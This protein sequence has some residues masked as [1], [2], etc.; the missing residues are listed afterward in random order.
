MQSHDA[1]VQGS[2]MW[3]LVSESQG[4]KTVLW[5]D[6]QIFPHPRIPVGWV[7]TVSSISLRIFLTS[8]GKLKTSQQFFLYCPWIPDPMRAPSRAEKGIWSLQSVYSTL[9]TFK[10]YCEVTILFSSKL[11]KKPQCKL[12]FFSCAIHN[13]NYF[14][15]I[16]WRLTYFQKTLVM[17]NC[18]LI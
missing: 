14:K 15:K 5:A 3:T 7:T 8:S 6:Y 18:V 16:F 9:W 2:D 12:F 1:T 4:R 17:E 10:P 11:K 13:F